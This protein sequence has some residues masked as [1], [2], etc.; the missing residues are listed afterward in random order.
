MNLTLLKKLKPGF[1]D[2]HDVAAGTEK[3]IF[4]FRRKWKLV[5]LLTAVVALI[6]LLAIALINFNVTHGAIASEVS[7]RT[8]QLLTATWRTFS[9]YLS[10]RRSALEFVLRDNTPVELNDS[11]RL[12]VILKNLKHGLGGFVDIGTVDSTG[13]QIAYAGPFPPGAM[14]YCEEKCFQ[15]VVRRGFFISELGHQNRLRQ[16]IVMA[17]RKDLPDGKFFVLRAT[18]SIRTV[19]EL[20][21][22]LE[23][24]EK[25]DAFIVN[26]DGILQTTSR[27]YGKPSGRANITVPGN[28]QKPRVIRNY[29]T[30][31]EPFL[32]GYAYIPETSFILMIMQNEAELM[33][34]WYSMR[35]KLIGLLIFCVAVVLVAI[36]CMATYLIHRIHTADQKRVIALHQVEY[37]NKMA[38][39][40]RLAAGVAH[41]VNNPLA[42]INE[43]AGLLSDLMTLKTRCVPD[44]R[45]PGIVADI[46]S[47]VA[48]CSAVTRRLLNFAR[49]TD[50]RIEPID[51]AEVIGESLAFLKKE[52]EY[53]RIRVTTTVPGDLPL[54]ESDRGSLE[55]ILLNLLNNAFSA[56]N[57]G[58]QL[59]ISAEPDGDHHVTLTMADNGCGIS[60][61]DLKRIFEPFFTTKS[62]EGSTGL[63]LSVTYGMVKQLGGKIAVQSE[64]GRGTRFNI[65][66]PV[67]L[68]EAVRRDLCEI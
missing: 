53:R 44:E 37:A 66:L 52:A 10:E 30:A 34:P 40:G 13:N 28:S 51:L 11:K 32:V 33:H 36:F 58:G 8:A 39:I 24:G 18:L 54:I 19:G 46:L 9:F 5:F 62:R 65:V 15:E 60:E 26:R 22:Q 4:S 29:N 48:R 67:K 3:S 1:W 49:H 14:N 63:G 43:K 50:I 64:L 59:D 31:G 41:E 42:V 16:H 20:L 38:S 68:D 61:E 23:L 27:Y 57:D 21:Q 35:L 17:I 2:H 25:G 47:T 56:M 12:A 7:Q 45:M 6:P 55:Q